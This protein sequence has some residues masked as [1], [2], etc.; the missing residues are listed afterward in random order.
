MIGAEL[1]HSHDHVF[2]VIIIIIIIIIINIIIN[3]RILLECR[4][5]KLLQEHFS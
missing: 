1:S 4:W 5:V 2:P 3:K